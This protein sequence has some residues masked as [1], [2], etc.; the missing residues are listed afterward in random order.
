MLTTTNKK[1]VA[2]AE[3]LRSCNYR[4]ASTVQELR[5][6]ISYYQGEKKRL[7][8]EKTL[9]K[10]DVGKMSALFKGWLN[11]LQN[12]NT[13]DVVEETEYFTNLVNNPSKSIA[14]I[15]QISNLKML[16]TTCQAPFYIE[17]TNKAWSLECGWENHE[18]LGL[19]CAFLQGEVCIRAVNVTFH[20]HVS[21]IIDLSDMYD[22]ADLSPD[23]TSDNAYHLPFAIC[24]TCEILPGVVCILTIYGPK[25][26]VQ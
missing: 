19:T 13:R 23:L 22:M 5:L 9:L 26:M 16:L 6:E 25:S 24:F 18:I 8:C 11:E 15:M 7:E 4:L 17:H 21:H 14:E 3:E 12:S 20:V 10:Q 1:E 2:E